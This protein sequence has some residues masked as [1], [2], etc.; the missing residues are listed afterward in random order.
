MRKKRISVKKLVLCPSFE[1]S[2][3]FEV[4][5]KMAERNHSQVVE[6]L[7]EKGYEVE[8]PVSVSTR[9]YV[10]QGR[11]DGVDR[12]RMRLAEVKPFK[13]DYSAVRQALM[14]RDMLFV[15]EGKLYRVVIYRYSRVDD[16][17][18]VIPSMGLNVLSEEVELMSMYREVMKVL[19]HS[20]FRIK[21]EVCERC[22][23]ASECTPQA[24]WRGRKLILYKRSVEV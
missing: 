2:K 11:V 12:K 19:N 22:K 10:I 3:D 16:R 14:Y 7:R 24:E 4:V 8:V 1:P 18:V 17:M 13:I 20:L 6:M 15:V 21:C 9:N 5:L 23:L